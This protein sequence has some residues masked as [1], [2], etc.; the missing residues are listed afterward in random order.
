MKTENRCR[1]GEKKKTET[2]FTWFIGQGLCLFHMFVAQECPRSAV[3][4]TPQNI[5][6]GIH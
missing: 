5:R 4:R 2:D 1:R 6:R 3:N